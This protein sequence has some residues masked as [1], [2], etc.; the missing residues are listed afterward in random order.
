MTYFFYAI[1][2][3]VPKTKYNM[4]SLQKIKATVM[5]NIASVPSQSRKFLISTKSNFESMLSLWE[6]DSKEVSRRNTGSTIDL[7]AIDRE[8]HP[9]VSLILAYHDAWNRHE[10]RNLGDF[11]TSDCCYYFTADRT[12]MMAS[13][14]FLFLEG[15]F[16]SLPD[17]KFRWK[18]ILQISETEFH[19]SDFQGS[20]THTG[21]PFAF[22][23]Y[24]Q[25][26]ASGKYIEDYPM[27]MTIELDPVTSKI[28]RVTINS[29]G[30]RVGPPFYYEALGGLI[31]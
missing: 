30:R 12:E 10:V 6:S 14:L 2:R 26:Q 7:D 4:Q 15:F 16:Q 9:G 13:E 25:L 23:P 20:G 18:S 17:A 11:I 27:Q 5:G 21:A 8:N 28:S 22:E 29:R 31:M 24:E 1:F 19:I 3:P